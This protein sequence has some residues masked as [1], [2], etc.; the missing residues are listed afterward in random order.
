MTIENLKVPEKGF[1]KAE[2]DWIKNVLIP[3]IK[4]VHA[5][6][7]HNVTISDGDEGQTI[8]ASDC[9]PCL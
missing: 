5:V 1:T 9:P 7:G 3:A 4:T 6:Q 2:R 8:N